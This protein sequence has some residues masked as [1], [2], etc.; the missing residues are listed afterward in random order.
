MAAM[1]GTMNTR[2]SNRIPLA[3]YKDRLPEAAAIIASEI[4]SWCSGLLE[5]GIRAS[6]IW[7]IERA[8]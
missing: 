8:V 7:T 1:A 6:V 2:L 3:G 5:L 4:G